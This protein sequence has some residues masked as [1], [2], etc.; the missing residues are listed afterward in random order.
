VAQASTE[1]VLQYSEQVLARYLKADNLEDKN[2]TGQTKMNSN[3][4][5]AP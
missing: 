1:D 4:K 5:Y 2:T 3:Q